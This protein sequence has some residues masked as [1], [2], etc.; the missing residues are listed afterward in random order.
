MVK[1][2]RLVILLSEKDIKRIK[3]RWKKEGNSLPLSTWAREE[4]LKINPWIKWLVRKGVLDSEHPD[5][6]EALGEV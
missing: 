1:K 2:M 3:S 6:K 4:L 5:V